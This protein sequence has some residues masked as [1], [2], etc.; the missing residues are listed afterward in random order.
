MHS[1]TRADGTP[2]TF[3][4]N[5]GGWFGA[6]IGG[7]SWI[8]IAAVLLAFSDPGLGLWLGV[9]VAA[10]NGLGISLW[11]QRDRIRAYPAVQLMIASVCVASLLATLV[12]DGHGRWDTL[13][14]GANISA[15][16][17]YLLIIGL[18]GGLFGS[19]HLRERHARRQ[20]EGAGP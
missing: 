17:M 8:A 5:G 7:T 11:L 14:T 3:R 19:F 15:G 20:R 6:L 4:W 13:G 10:V 16:Q 9:I 12:I 1:P 2:S 18:F